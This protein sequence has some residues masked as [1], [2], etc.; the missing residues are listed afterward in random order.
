MGS[1]SVLKVARD[2]GRNSIGIELSPEY[3]DLAK[4]KLGFYQ[5]SLFSEEVYEVK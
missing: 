2:L 4:E 3:I 1:G 5:K